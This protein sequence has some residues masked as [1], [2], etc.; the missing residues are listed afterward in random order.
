[1]NKAQ[2]N[3]SEFD[4]ELK[5][6]ESLIRFPGD[7]EEITVL[8][9]KKTLPVAIYR[10]HD[11]DGKYRGEHF[12]LV[13]PTVAKEL[14][15]HMRKVTFHACYSKDEGPLIIAQKNNTS[16][17]RNIWNSSLARILDTESGKYFKISRSHQGN[18]YT[19]MDIPEFS[20]DEDDIVSPKFPDFEGKLWESLSDKVIDS[21]DHPIIKKL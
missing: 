19:S 8:G 15:N 6:D 20:V 7:D 10:E 14:P 4:Y 21:L 13:A 12:Y 5:Q 1:M 18:C 11:E 9:M 2:F 16:R 3:L 17:N